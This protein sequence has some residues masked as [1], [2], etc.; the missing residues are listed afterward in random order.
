MWEE[1]LTQPALWPVACV[2]REHNGTQVYEGRAG[3]GRKAATSVHPHWPTLLF[4]FGAVETSWG[5]WGGLRKQ[6]CILRRLLSQSVCC[7]CRKMPEM[8]NL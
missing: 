1:Q 3:G 2:R 8:S 7:C 6:I 5:T 4:C